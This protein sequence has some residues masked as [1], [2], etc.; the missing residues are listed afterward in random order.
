MEAWLLYQRSNRNRVTSEN[1][2]VGWEESLHQVDLI[3]DMKNDSKCLAFALAC[4]HAVQFQSYTVTETWKLLY[5]EVTAE[6]KK[7]IK[8]L[9]L[10]VD[11]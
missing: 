5:K 11:L 9:T 3:Q 8:L 10:K 4:K 2:P 7:Y 1:A 6:L